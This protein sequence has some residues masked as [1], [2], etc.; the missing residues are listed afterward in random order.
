[1]RKFTQYEE[2]R[3]ARRLRKSLSSNPYRYRSS[4]KAAAWNKGW[5]AA[6]D[7]LRIEFEAIG[8]QNIT[9]NVG[10]ADLRS[11]LDGCQ[12][13]TLQTW[14]ATIGSNLVEYERSS[15]NGR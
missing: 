15:H 5:L 8:V 7:A 9:G 3:Q 1:M 12:M 10:A 4:L 14:L 6:D 2:G 13:L 11:G